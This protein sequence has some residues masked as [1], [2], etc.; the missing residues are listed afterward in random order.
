MKKPDY[1]IP[2]SDWEVMCSQ[3]GH[4]GLVSDFPE[5]KCTVCANE[6]FIHGNGFVKKLRGY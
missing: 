5:K 4:K 6:L 3:C 2:Y 1:T